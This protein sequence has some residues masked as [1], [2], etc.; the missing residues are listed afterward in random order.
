MQPW[1]HGAGIAFDRDCNANFTVYRHPIGSTLQTA[2]VNHSLLEE[3][4]RKIPEFT[5]FKANLQQAVDEERT[6]PDDP[7]AYCFVSEHNDIDISYTVGLFSDEIDRDL[8]A[9]IGS[10][11]IEVS[12]EVRA[13][14][15]FLSVLF[16]YNFTIKVT[17]EIFDLYDFN[18]GQRTSRVPLDNIELDDVDIHTSGAWLQLGYEPL[19]N[20]GRVFITEIPFVVEFSD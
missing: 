7:D 19:R 15:R 11:K 12:L 17:G 20:R 3:R 10:A 8:T 6:C 18:L 9:A 1:S 16:G 13:E 14:P 5:S 4:L 2:V